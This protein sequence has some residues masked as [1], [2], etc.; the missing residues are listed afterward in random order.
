MIRAIVTADNSFLVD[1][2]ASVLAQELSLDVLQLTYRQ[3][4]HVYQAVRDQRSVVIDVDEG[5]AVDELLIMPASFR[6]EDPLLLIRIALPRQC[7]HIFRSYALVNRQTE[8]VV[9][10]VK[11]FCRG[12]LNKRG[13]A[14]EAIRSAWSIAGGME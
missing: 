10:M 9:K 4:Q 3:P 13:R 6:I 5:Q 11:D 14:S 8:V 12:H 2:V 7:I 1:S